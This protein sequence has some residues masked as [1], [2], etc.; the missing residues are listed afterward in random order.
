MY[1]GVSYKERIAAIGFLAAASGAAAFA[2]Q[3]S[4]WSWPWSN[5]FR[6]TVVDEDARPAKPESSAF[7]PDSAGPSIAEIDTHQ[8]AAPTELA[9]PV[10]DWSWDQQPID[11][12]LT[13]LTPH[14]EDVVRSYR[15]NCPQPGKTIRLI[16]AM[17]VG[18]RLG[19]SYPGTHLYMTVDSR[20][21]EVRITN[22]M[23]ADDGRSNEPRV[24]A[25]IDVWGDLQLHGISWDGIMDQCFR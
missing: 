23:R 24:V 11:K 5:E 18:L 22:Q 2:S 4:G 20:G 10:Q 16:D 15:I 17:R 12:Y 1:R 14:A 21:D 9:A 8:T 3:Q 7:P 19:S 6:Q 25:T 13:F